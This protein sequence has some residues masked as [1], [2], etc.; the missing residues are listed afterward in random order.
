MPSQALY[1]ESQARESLNASTNGPAD[2]S[3]FGPAGSGPRNKGM[4][5]GKL[6]RVEEGE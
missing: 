2:G 6:I 5:L 1:E 4:G 3:S